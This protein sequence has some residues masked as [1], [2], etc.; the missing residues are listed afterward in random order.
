MPTPT[1]LLAFVAAVFVIVLIPGPSV[2]FV[3]SRALVAGRRT[4]VRT[5]LGNGLGGMVTVL[6]VAV[7]LGTL[8]TRFAPLFVA[9]KLVGAAYLIYLGVQAIRHRHRLAESLDAA[10]ETAG[11]PRRAFWDGFVVGATN[12]KTLVFFL[13]VL[14]QFVDPGA[15]QVPV[16]MLALGTLAVTIGV[17]T[18]TCYG[19]L[20]GTVRR[21]FVR[22]PRRMAV[23]GAVSGAVMIGLGAQFAVTGRRA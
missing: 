14:P 15:G 19:L 3:V 11:R 16:Q 4:A 17:L 23:T 6:V 21:W 9:V 18:D 20:A 22:V 13:A 12:P 5:A 1:T 7:G 10:P 8:V 2:L